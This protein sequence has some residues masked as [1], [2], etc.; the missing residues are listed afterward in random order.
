MKFELKYCGYMNII[1]VALSLIYPSRITI[2]LLIVSFFFSTYISGRYYEN[3]IENLKYN[4]PQR[5]KRTK[6]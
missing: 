3:I 6:A 4:K 2:G 1:V 5:Y